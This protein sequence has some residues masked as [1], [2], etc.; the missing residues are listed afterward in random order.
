MKKSQAFGL[1][2]TSIATSPHNRDEKLYL[3]IA[4]HFVIEHISILGPVES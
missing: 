2:E 3:A 4:S 1:A